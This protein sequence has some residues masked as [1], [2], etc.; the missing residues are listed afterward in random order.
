[1]Y[2]T[3][4]T[5]RVSMGTRDPFTSVTPRYL[6]HLDDIRPGPRL[7]ENKV[8]GERGVRLSSRNYHKTQRPIVTVDTDC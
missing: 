5:A 2:M 6:G 3:V 7:L 8:L 4:R 1:M